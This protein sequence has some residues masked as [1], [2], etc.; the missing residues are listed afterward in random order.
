MKNNKSY[1][2]FYIS[3]TMALLPFVVS[4]IG[5]MLLNTQSNLKDSCLQI[6]NHSSY[7]ERSLV[8]VNDESQ[9][10]SGVLVN[11]REFGELIL[12]SS[13][14]LDRNKMQQNLYE[15]SLFN[16]EKINP[17]FGDF[18]P[19]KNIG[20]FQFS[21]PANISSL[22]VSETQPA[23]GE[24]GFTGTLINGEIETY[25][26]RYS[27]SITLDNGNLIHIYSGSIDIQY[28]GSP[29]VDQCGNL[30]GVIIEGS[31]RYFAISS[32]SPDV[33]ANSFK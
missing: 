5:F 15:I 17:V 8:T 33:F 25:Q 12:T 28:E 2:Q 18:V 14:R 21:T 31:D 1:F 9:F 19:N 10:L 3:I 11:D 22:P 4:V 7:I 20:F 32:L 23:I 27:N 29:V 30:L 6:Y 13:R 26:G 24:I 16:T